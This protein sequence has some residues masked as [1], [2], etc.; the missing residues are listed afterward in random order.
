MIKLFGP[1]LVITPIKEKY[2]GL[3]VLPPGMGRR[4]HI[5]AEVVAVGDGRQSDGKPYASEF[6][7]GD[8]ALIQTND[9]I[10]NAYSFK[11]GGKDCLTV[12]EGDV[13]AKVMSPTVKLETFKIAGYWA[14]LEPFMNEL[15]SK[16]V[17]PDNLVETSE[18][19]RFRL[20]QLGSRSEVR[21]ELGSEVICDKSR[22]NPFQI[23]DAT[24]FYVPT[25]SLVGQLC[26]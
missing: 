26:D 25:S 20:V 23:Q 6:K 8:I 12:M 16:I 7:T 19:Q 4:N 17:L 5:L 1:R 18:H 21:P 24:Y 11:H 10:L 13:V 14:L 15:K 9:V 2:D 3:V 22:L